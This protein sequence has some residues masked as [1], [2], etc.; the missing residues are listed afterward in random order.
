MPWQESAYEAKA[1]TGRAR[2]ASTRSR[3][4][5]RATTR[6]PADRRTIDTMARLIQDT[7][8]E[9]CEEMSSGPT[10]PPDACRVGRLGRPPSY[11]FAPRQ[12]ARHA[13]GTGH[14]N[15][16]EVSRRPEGQAPETE[17]RPL[18]PDSAIAII[19]PCAFDAAAGPCYSED[20]TW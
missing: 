7:H 18:R 6:P 10:T 3:P 4:L 5:A 16:G 2:H 17:R 14:A 20:I 8:Y 15:D 13:L 1:A 19:S 12:P 9:R 11:P